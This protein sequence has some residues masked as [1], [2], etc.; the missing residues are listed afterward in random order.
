MNIPRRRPG[1]PRKDDQRDT[2]EL[3]LRAATELF[4]RRG[5]DAVGVR[6]VATA[7]G[8]D[9]ATVHHHLGSKAQ[10]YEACFARVFVAESQALGAAIADARA[11]LAEGT[12]DL[13]PALH[14]VI[15]AFVDF[16]EERPETTG[17]WLRRWLD[18]QR[19][20][21]L[22]EHYSLPLYTQ[23]KDVLAA[24][25]AAGVLDEPTP[26]LAV[27]SLVWTVHAHVVIILAGE[28]SEAQRGE[29]RAFV[30]RW[31]DRMYAPR[32]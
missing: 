24:A 23:V 17:L 19:H 32:A 7:A 29:L 11:A 14:Q 30:H 4:A 18:P 28:L 20:A 3:I 13:L 2:G 26:H 8:V 25:H 1:R 22:D 12:V 21:G 10:L 5:F 9:V 15:D 16:L 31:L 6:D 27:R